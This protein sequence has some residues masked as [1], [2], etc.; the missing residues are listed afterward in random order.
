MKAPIF[1]APNPNHTRGDGDTD[2]ISE[3]RRTASSYLRALS[4]MKA[5]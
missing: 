1:D 5:N 3:K 4:A 2:R